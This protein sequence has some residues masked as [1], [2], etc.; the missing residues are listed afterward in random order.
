MSYIKKIILALALI[1]FPLVLFA[2]DVLNANDLKPVSSIT[3]AT[4]VGKFTINATA[5]KNVSIDTNEAAVNTKEGDIFN[6]K[7]NLKGGGSADF[8]SIKF[9][10][11]KDASIKI[12]LASSSKTDARVLKL[13][14]AKGD[15]VAEFTATPYSGEFAALGSAK[16]PADGEYYLTAASGGIYV[17]EIII[18]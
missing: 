4:K 14:N 9:S 7:V 10:A 15:S 5:D 17:Y 6:N 3:A 8:R 11:K 12:Y 2:E 16:I 1:A 13:F 18:K